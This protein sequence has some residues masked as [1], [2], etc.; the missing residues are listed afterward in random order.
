MPEPPWIFSVVPWNPKQLRYAVT[1]LV[2][3]GA[4][5]RMATRT[6]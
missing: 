1:S 5:P 3:V 2:G 4:S 6:P